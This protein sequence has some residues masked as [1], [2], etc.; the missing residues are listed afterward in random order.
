MEFASA[1][2]ALT[3]LLKLSQSLKHFGVDDLIDVSWQSQ[4]LVNTIFDIHCGNLKKRFVDISFTTS[5]PWFELQASQKLLI[6]YNVAI[7]YYATLC[8]WTWNI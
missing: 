6:A 2:I 7:G 3:Q 5:S 8:D 4:I 1:Q